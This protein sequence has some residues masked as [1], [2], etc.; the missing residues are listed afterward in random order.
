MFKQAMLLSLIP[1]IIMLVLMFSDFRQALLQAEMIAYIPVIYVIAG[2][3]LL[4]TKH[5][6]TGIM[7]WLSAGLIVLLARVIIFIIIG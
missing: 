3:I 5:Q 1:L 4:F 2:G 7:L 6:K